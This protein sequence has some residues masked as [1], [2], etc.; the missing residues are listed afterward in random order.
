MLRLF[1]GRIFLPVGF[2][3]L[4]CLE[5]SHVFAFGFLALALLAPNAPPP[6]LADAAAAALLAVGA[7]PPV[8][9][10]AA[11]AALLAL[12]AP[13]PVLADAAAAAVLALVA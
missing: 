6:M 4:C 3:D 2:L 8:L 9:T 10:D 1:L 13:P 7:L 5:Y 12:A 11:T